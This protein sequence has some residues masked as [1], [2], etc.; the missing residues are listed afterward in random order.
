MTS[1]TQ[2]PFFNI[3]LVALAAAFAAAGAAQAGVAFDANL[4]LDIT[5]RSGKATEGPAPAFQSGVNTGGRV[6]LNANAELVKNGDNYVTARGTLIVPVNGDKV[7][8]DDA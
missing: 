6:E 2:S 3:R 4:E 8:I 1:T 5:N 7:T